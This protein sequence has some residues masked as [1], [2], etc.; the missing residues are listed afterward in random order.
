MTCMGKEE[1]AITNVSSRD[2]SRQSVSTSSLLKTPTNVSI[3]DVSRRSV[4]TS[5]MIKIPASTEVE[6][7]SCGK[8]LLY[9]RCMIGSRPESTS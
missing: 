6:M 2:I 5:S 3:H 8:I 4:A 1:D 7:Q 9:H